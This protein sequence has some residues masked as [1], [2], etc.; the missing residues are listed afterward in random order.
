[1]GQLV[2][3]NLTSWFSGKGPLTPVAETRLAEKALKKAS[4]HTSL[5]CFERR[6]IAF[7]R[8]A[9]KGCERRIESSGDGMNKAAG[10]PERLAGRAE[11]AAPEVSFAKVSVAIR[12]FWRLRSQAG[13][14]PLGANGRGRPLSQRLLSRQLPLQAR[15]ADAVHGRRRVGARRTPRPTAR[16]GSAWAPAKRRHGFVLGAPPACRAAIAAMVGVTG[17]TISPDRTIA[18]LDAGGANDRSTSR[19]TARDA[20]SRRR[21]NA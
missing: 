14:Q 20:S 5:S 11:P 13:R 10:M 2:V 6:I 7:R 16:A 21:R 19:P 3:D 18:F 1:M 9:A 15:L 8:T 12:C 4:D 17:W